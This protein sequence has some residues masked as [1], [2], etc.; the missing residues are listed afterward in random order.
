MFRALKK[1]AP[2][3]FTLFYRLNVKLSSSQGFH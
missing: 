2:D 1:G 3:T